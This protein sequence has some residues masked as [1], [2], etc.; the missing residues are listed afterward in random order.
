ML[1][2]D[3]THEFG[4]AGLHIAAANSDYEMAKILLQEYNA[5]PNITDMCNPYIGNARIEEFSDK[6]RPNAPTQGFTPL[7]YAVA[8]FD[9]SMIKLLI[10]HGA[11]PN[12]TDSHGAKPADY[13]DI[14]NQ[15]AQHIAQ[16]FA[17]F[18]SVFSFFFVIYL[19]IFCIHLF[20]FV[21]KGVL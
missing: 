21:F 13:L 2:A 1:D 8:L 4:F 20:F 5:N 19:L 11:D 10:N 15:K 7:H 12:I 3:S 18:F 17:P 6:I 14:N 9:E 16:V